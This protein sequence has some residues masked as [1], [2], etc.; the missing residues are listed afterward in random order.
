MGRC[1]KNR[2]SRLLLNFY[3]NRPRMLGV[4]QRPGG[5]Q[6]IEAGFKLGPYGEARARALK[7]EVW[8]SF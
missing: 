3:L 7:V 1:S 2:R 6:Y 8:E 5:I 4:F